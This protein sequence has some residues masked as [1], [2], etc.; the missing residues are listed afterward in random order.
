M[1][2]IVEVSYWT[3]REREV[4]YRYDITTK[5]KARQVAFFLMKVYMGIFAYREEPK[6]KWTREDHGGR[7]RSNKD[8]EALYRRVKREY[9]EWS[10]DYYRA[11]YAL[12]NE[13]NEDDILNFLNK[14]CCDEIIHIKVYSLDRKCEVPKFLYQEY[15]D[16]IEVISERIDGEIAARQSA[17]AVP[18][19][20]L[21]DVDGSQPVVHEPNP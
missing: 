21:S 1:S 20:L 6:K 19:L 3:G 15:K 2:R 16:Q 18:E 8:D 9:E 14:H 10:E 11:K 4:E 5:R 7:F 12:L 17:R 13:G